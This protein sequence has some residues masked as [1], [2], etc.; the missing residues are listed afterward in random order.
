MLAERKEA[1]CL[2]LAHL[3]CQVV[4]ATVRSIPPDGTA[5]Q[6]AGGSQQN[7]RVLSQ[8]AQEPVPVV[9]HGRI[10]YW[11]GFEALLHYT[12]YQQA[13]SW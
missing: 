2:N 1:T 10:T 5:E 13:I 4:P 7:G 9:E 8:A 12:L 6:S 3:I 11:P